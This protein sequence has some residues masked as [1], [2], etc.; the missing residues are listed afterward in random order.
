MGACTPK[1]QYSNSVYINI[2]GKYV[3]KE[4]VVVKIDDDVIYNEISNTRQFSEVTQ[5]PLTLNKRQIKIYFAVNGK[6]T[7]LVF[8]LKKQNY[9]NIGYSDI[10]HQFQFYSLDSTHFFNSKT[11]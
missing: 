5:G 6:D 11:D 1:Q 4:R 7:S 10:K 8:P 2:Y 9:L 3:N